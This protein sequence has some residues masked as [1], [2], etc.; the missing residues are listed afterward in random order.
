MRDETFEVAIRVLVADNT[1]LHT[2]LLADALRRDGAFEV[3]GSDSRELTARGDLNNI[4]VLLI[5]SDL[6]EQPARGFEVLREV[7]SLHPNLHAIMLL[8]C[9][10]PKLVLEAF[11]IGARGVLSHQESVDTLR[12]CVRRVHQGQ[13]WANTQQ[14]DL[15]VQALGSF[16]NLATLSM[17]GMEQLSRREAEVV[18]SVAQGLSNR[19]IAE[20]MGLSQHTIKN[21]LFR[22]FDKLGVSSRVELLSLTVAGMGQP[23]AAASLFRKNDTDRNLLDDSILGKCQK[24]AEDGEPA[25]QLELARFYWSRRTDSKNL[26]QAYRWYLIAGQQLSRT[27]A[28][29]AKAMTMDQILHAQ[30]MATEWLKKTAKRP[31]LSIREELPVPPAQSSEPAP[32]PSRRRPALVRSLPQAPAAVRRLP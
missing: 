1:R 13:I 23:E 21:Y 30:Q 9:S 22:I 6:D 8:D 20:R 2:Q 27:S 7:R 31:P 5:S 28:S 10:K 4:D 32:G 15:M 26:I 3:I 19:Q 25:A 12:K 14:M 11:R 17:R 24:A 29:V 16:R 18:E